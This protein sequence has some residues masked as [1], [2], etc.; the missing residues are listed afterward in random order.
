[1]GLLSG[2]MK[3]RWAEPAAVKPVWAQPKGVFRCSSGISKALQDTR[4]MHVMLNGY[5]ERFRRS[6]LRREH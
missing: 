1:M 2:I 4:S 3:G 6:L 5:I